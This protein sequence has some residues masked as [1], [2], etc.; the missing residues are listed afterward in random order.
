MKQGGEDWTL[1]RKRAL[2]DQENPS[3]KKDYLFSNRGNIIKKGP[4][5]GR[6]RECKLFFGKIRPGGIWHANTKRKGKP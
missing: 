2:P 5:I 6:G 4:G 3:A 1:H